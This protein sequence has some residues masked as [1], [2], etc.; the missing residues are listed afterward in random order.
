MMLSGHSS[1]VHVHHVLK[2]GDGSHG[3]TSGVRSNLLTGAPYRPYHLTGR[4]FPVFLGLLHLPSRPGHAE[5]REGALSHLCLRSGAYPV[6]GVR[7]PSVFWSSDNS[8][9]SKCSRGRTIYGG[10]DEK[11]DREGTELALNATHCPPQTAP[12]PIKSLAC[13]ISGRRPRVQPSPA[14]VA[15][16]A[17]SAFSLDALGGA[18]VGF[19]YGRGVGIFSRGVV[20]IG[21]RLSHAGKPLPPSCKVGPP[22]S[23]AAQ[24]RQVRLGLL[25]YGVRNHSRAL[26][27]ASTSELCV[28]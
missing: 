22:E 26:G 21:H 18:L 5:A 24:P 9:S 20:V 23:W 4:Q 2:I 17:R 13:R 1:S 11:G 19:S 25:S 28:L 16:C 7:F 14:A 8:H 15:Q 3:W 10:E 27:L 6:I 12:A